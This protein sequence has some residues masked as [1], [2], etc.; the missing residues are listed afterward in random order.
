MSNKI[1]DQLARKKSP[2]PLKSQKSKKQL[3]PQHSRY[4][5]VCMHSLLRV[6]WILTIKETAMVL[7]S[8]SKI[9]ESV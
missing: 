6:N 8:S 7:K 5:D 4:V 3:S 2:P 1:K 9:E